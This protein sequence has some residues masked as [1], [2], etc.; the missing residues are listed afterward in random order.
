M[1]TTGIDDVTERDGATDNVICPPEFALPEAITQHDG[2][3]ST[4]VPRSQ[5]T[6]SKGGNTERGEELQGYPHPAEGFRP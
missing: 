4:G 3:R 1:P 2:W 6:T 5:V